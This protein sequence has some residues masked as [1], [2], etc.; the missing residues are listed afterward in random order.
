MSAANLFERYLLALNKTSV[1]EKT[2]KRF[3]VL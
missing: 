1:E 2:D 3:A